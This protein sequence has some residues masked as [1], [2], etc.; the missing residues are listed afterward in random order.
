LGYVGLDDSTFAALSEPFHLGSEIPLI[1]A[2]IEAG[3][4]RA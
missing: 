2:A 4:Q 1:Q 3:Y